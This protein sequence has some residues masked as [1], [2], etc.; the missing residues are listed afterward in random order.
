MPHVDPFAR[1]VGGALTSHSAGRL[2]SGAEVVEYRLSNRRG[3]CAKILTLGALLREFHVPDA[4]GDF[5]DVV[6][7]FDD[8]ADYLRG[9]DYFGATI[10]RY[11][12]RIA[13]GRF[14]L[15]GKS[16]RLPVNSG[17]NSE[18]GGT[19]GFDRRLWSVAATE[20]GEEVALELMLVS[21]DGDQG[22]PGELTVHVRYALTEHDELRIDYRATTTATTVINLTNHT[23]WDLGGQGD[24]LRAR[25]RIEADHYAV[26]DADQIPTGELRAVAGSAL[27]FR[28][29]HAIDARIRDG[30][31]PQLA[32]GRGYDHNFVLRGGGG[33]L[34]LAAC[35]DD[36]R[37][38]RSLELLTTE[39]G[40][41]LYSGNWLS[42]AV[43]G[44]RQRLYRAGDGIALEPQHFPDSPN[45]P[46]FPSTVLEP[47]IV[48]RSTTL[49]R[50]SAR[51]P[52]RAERK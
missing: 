48:W 4:R 42:G 2:P 46:E 3:S 35:L 11:A 13:G 33:T 44:K 50:L 28:E 30:R 19:D 18:H 25:L 23:Y 52:Q 26:L 10:G 6:L 32:I 7:G 27:D 47:G 21:P 9:T 20:I 45:R 40:L 5:G 38:G 1:G 41:Q 37:S 36:P 14:S 51:A 49:Y 24:A 43:I 34:R 31:E 16:Y 12:N 22:Y 15:H 8:A 29:F 39:P 17:V